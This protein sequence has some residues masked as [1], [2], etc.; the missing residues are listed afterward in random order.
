[1]TTL[2]HVGGVI[3]TYTIGLLMD[4]LGAHRMVLVAL[5]ARRRSGSTRS[6]P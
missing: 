3:G 5:A 1:M 2:Y 4:R 6:R